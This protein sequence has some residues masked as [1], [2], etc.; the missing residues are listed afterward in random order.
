M[1]LYIIMNNILR[2]ISGGL[3]I[4]ALAA[5]VTLLVG[6]VKLGILST[7]P[8]A[9]ISATPLLL[10]GA[11]YL[12]LQPILR[13]GWTELLKNTLVAGTFLF[14]GAIQLM[15]RNGAA[16]RLGDVVIAL[17]VLDLAWVILGSRTSSRRN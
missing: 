17:Y 9:A 2:W 12:I 4:V 11:A 1:Q 13:P 8:P 7:L 6:N 16:K 5:S 3:A 10:V 14:W 15:P